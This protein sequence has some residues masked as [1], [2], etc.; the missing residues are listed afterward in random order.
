MT[1][2]WTPP[3]SL[4][5]QV[6]PHKDL[7][8]WA[9]ASWREGWGG[10][11]G[12]RER[13]FALSLGNV[14]ESFM[15]GT[16]GAPRM[17]QQH[18]H[19]RDTL[20]H[21][22]AFLSAVHAVPGDH[23]G[24]AET[25][26]WRVAVGA[27]RGEDAKL[28]GLAL[29]ESQKGQKSLLRQSSGFPPL[30]CTLLSIFFSFPYHTRNAVLLPSRCQVDYAAYHILAPLYLLFNLFLVKCLNWCTVI[31]ATW[32][33]PCHFIWTNQSP[34]KCVLKH[35]INTST[36]INKAAGRGAGIDSHPFSWGFFLQLVLKRLQ[37]CIQSQLVSPYCFIFFLF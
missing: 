33:L 31:T 7:P 34:V 11:G 32:V 24:S 16:L 20:V 30:S 19:G 15:N 3:L 28:A 36:Q 25:D 18:C 6:L 10:L 13:S 35:I 21:P 22:A 26:F 23:R 9:A 27:Q 17:G 1:L 4:F 37:G 2:S 29:S 12:Q 8:Q 5:S 14:A